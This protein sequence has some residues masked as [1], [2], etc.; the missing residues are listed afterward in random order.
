MYDCGLD[1]FISSFLVVTYRIWVYL[2]EKRKTNYSQASEVNHSIKLKHTF[3][4]V[5]DVG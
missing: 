5:M 3:S 4:P 1:A 2:S